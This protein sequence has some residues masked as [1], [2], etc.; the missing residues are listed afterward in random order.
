VIGTQNDTGWYTIGDD[1]VF[2]SRHVQCGESQD[3]RHHNG[4]QRSL[5]VDVSHFDCEF[6][7]Q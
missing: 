5:R 1:I 7:T 2:G 3:Y 4:G 6:T